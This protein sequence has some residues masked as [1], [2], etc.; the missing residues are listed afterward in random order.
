MDRLTKIRVFAECELQRV[1]IAE[2]AARETYLQ[3]LSVYDL[4]L[5]HAAQTRKKIESQVLDDVL[6]IINHCSD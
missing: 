1:A 5:Y 4:A 3:S 2:A 6:K